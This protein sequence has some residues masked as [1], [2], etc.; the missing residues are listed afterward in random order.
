MKRSRD[1]LI[2]VI[3][4]PNSNGLNFTELTPQRLE[5]LK[6]IKD[7]HES[8]TTVSQRIK[9][10][11]DAIPQVV[12]SNEG[13]HR[14][15]YNNFT[16]NIERVRE[17]DSDESPNKRCRLS[18]GGADANIKPSCI[19]C[20]VV[21]RKQKKIMGTME[22]VSQLPIEHIDEL[23][24]VAK[25]R[26]DINIM[27][28][29]ERFDI[30]PG[31]VWCHRSC[32][33]SY[34][35]MSLHWRSTNVQHKEQQSSLVSAHNDA[36][37]AVASIVDEEVIKDQK[38]ISLSD[39]KKRYIESLQSTDH[40]NDS[41]RNENL[42][43]KLKQRY[44]S[45]IAFSAPVYNGKFQSSLVY[46]AVMKV[47]DAVSLA[48]E[49]GATD[50]IRDAALREREEILKSHRECPAMEWPV[51]AYE[52]PSAKDL[53]PDGLTKLLRLLLTGKESRGCE[54]TERHILSIGNSEHKY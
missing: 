5:K 50:R 15:C 27:L 42:K 17:L 1:K 37:A 28:K 32:R 31:P 24:E 53:L 18:I 19:L 3:H 45:A 20:G 35:N 22:H 11:D 38:I 39:L 8:S 12:S 2:C 40:K 51:T 43:A 13:Y 6:E 54:K 9:N 25:K 34:S 41:Y 26:N 14:D 48:Y 46:N 49:L 29:L 47:G 23:K 4:W 36:I 44:G 16:K 21:S 33:Y 10:Y 52:L 30:I 7:L